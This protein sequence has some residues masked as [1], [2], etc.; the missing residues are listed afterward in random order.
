MIF[1][2]NHTPITYEQLQET[3]KDFNSNRK[4]LPGML[5]H[6]VV[7][8][9][10]GL[11]IPMIWESEEAATAFYQSIEF[12]CPYTVKSFQVLEHNFVKAER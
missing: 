8:T 2:F 12:P 10:S 3:E 4:L 6:A 7:Q 1:H 11:L 5:S 9:E